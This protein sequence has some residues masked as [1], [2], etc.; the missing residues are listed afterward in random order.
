MQFFLKNKTLTLAE[1]LGG[2]ES[3]SKLFGN[4]GTRIDL[5]DKRKKLE[6]PMI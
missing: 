4:D 3:L 1:S 2:V 5:K 6:S